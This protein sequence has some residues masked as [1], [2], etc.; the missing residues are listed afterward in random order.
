MR[1]IR[2]IHWMRWPFFFQSHPY[3]PSPTIWVVTGYTC[4]QPVYFWVVIGYTCVS[5]CI[6]VQNDL[7]QTVSVNCIDRSNTL[8]SQ[9]QIPFTFH[10]L[11]VL[12]FWSILVS[13]FETALLDLSQ[14]KHVDPFSCLLDMAPVALESKAAVLSVNRDVHVVTDCVAKLYDILMRNMVQQR[15][16]Q[17]Q[18]ATFRHL[19]Y[20][21]TKTTVSLKT[22]LFVLLAA[23][24]LIT[25]LFGVVWIVWLF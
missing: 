25:C 21:H 4:V 17:L 6:S 22:M 11:V 20:V 13:W 8:C 24:H 7:W 16:R 19:K 10:R 9:K 1:P 15:A 18:S 5:L 3:L 14:K 23:L 2:V 12:G